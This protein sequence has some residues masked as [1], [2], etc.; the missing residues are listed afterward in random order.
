MRTQEAVNIQ[1][2]NTE[3]RSTI[4]RWLSH[5][6]L[7]QGSLKSQLLLLSLLFLYSHNNLLFSLK[8]S[9]WSAAKQYTT[10]LPD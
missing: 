8:V 6:K 4:S 9:K 1:L 7:A 10:D 3:V 5:F 2:R